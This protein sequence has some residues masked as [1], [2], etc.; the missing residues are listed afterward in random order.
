MSNSPAA[1]LPATASVVFM[2]VAGCG[3]STLAAAVAT[4]LGR[5]WLEGDGLHSEASRH[6]MARGEPLTDQDR[7]GWLDQLAEQL[8]LHPGLLLTCSALKRSYR[9]RL[10]AASPGL[11]FAFLDLDRAEA[12]RRVAARSSQFFAA[13]LVAS[14]FQTLEPPRDEPGVLHLDARLPLRELET[15]VCHWLGRA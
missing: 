11:R 6:K 1:T 12:R 5:D 13:S 9:D 2:G 3:K 7:A 4:R 8:R 10:R 15:R 14:Q